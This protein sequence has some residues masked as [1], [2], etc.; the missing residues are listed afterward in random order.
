MQDVVETQLVAL[1]DG[2]IPIGVG[3]GWVLYD[4]RD[5]KAAKPERGSRAR[6]EAA[7]RRDLTYVTY[8]RTL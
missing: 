5:G 8:A 7:H 1:T 6:Q 2:A 4:H 3:L